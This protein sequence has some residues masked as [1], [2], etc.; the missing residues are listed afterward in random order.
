MKAMTTASWQ[1]AK[2]FYGGL[3]DELEVQYPG[4]YFKLHTETLKYALGDPTKDNNWGFND[5]SNNHRGEHGVL[6]GE[7]FG[8]TIGGYKW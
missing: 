8:V 7:Y 6:Y 5:A 4:W 2:D 1:R 3:K